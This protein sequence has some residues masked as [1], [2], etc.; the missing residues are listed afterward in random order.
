[1]SEIIKCMCKHPYQDML[2]G[3]GNRVANRMRSG[4]MKCTVCG[5]ISGSKS[6]I[7]QVDKVA[8]AKMKKEVEEVKKVEEKSKEVK[9]EK[10]KKT[11]KGPKVKKEKKKDP[12]LKM[13]K[14]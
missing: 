10:S 7:S 1:M 5:A 12:G 3:V 11:G 6:V 8:I 9:E 14:K 2:Y 4:Q 13:G